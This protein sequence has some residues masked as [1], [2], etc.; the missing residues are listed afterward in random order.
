MPVGRCLDLSLRGDN[1]IGYG[2]TGRRGGSGSS[3][4]F[5]RND[6][7]DFYSSFTIP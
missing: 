4:K 5:S 6:Y 2:A 7:E 1:Q 3:D